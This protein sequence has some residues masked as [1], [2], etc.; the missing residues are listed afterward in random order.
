MQM[1]DPQN[2]PG[3]ECSARQKCVK[4][5]TK[6]SRKHL[7][8]D[9]DHWEHSSTDI[10]N[11][12]LQ[13]ASIVSEEDKTLC[14]I[15]CR[16]ITLAL[17]S[18]SSQIASTQGDIKT[19]TSPLQKAGSVIMNCTAIAVNDVSSTCPLLQVCIPLVKQARANWICPCPVPFFSG[20]HEAK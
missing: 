9:V 7:F 18:D 8:L 6:S 15:Q 2:W 12:R 13:T 20:W 10:I 14:R 17:P 1:V 4:S 19:N 3:Y 11:C 16:A 5:G